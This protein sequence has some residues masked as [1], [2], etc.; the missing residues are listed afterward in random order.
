MT[1]DVEETAAAAAADAAASATDASASA[2]DASASATM[3]VRDFLLIVRANTTPNDNIRII[4]KCP[5][6]CINP[7][8]ELKQ[9]RYYVYL[10]FHTLNRTSQ[11]RQTGASFII[12]CR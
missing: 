4:I 8:Y 7:L 1:V 5:F 10:L 11:E 3:V 9:C 6:S 12:Q 2:T